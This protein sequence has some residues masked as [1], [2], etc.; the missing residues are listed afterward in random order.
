[1]DFSIIIMVKNIYEN[2]SNTNYSMRIFINV[3]NLYNFQLKIGILD[4]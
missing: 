2:F 3:Q 1:M 4:N